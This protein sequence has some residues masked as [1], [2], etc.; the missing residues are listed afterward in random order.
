MSVPTWDSGSR[1][2]HNLYHCLWSLLWDRYT[3][4]ASTVCIVPIIMIFPPF[5]WHP[6]ALPS[7]LKSSQECHC[8]C[9][10]QWSLQ[11]SL[12]WVWVAICLRFETNT[13]FCP[14]ETSVIRACISL[15]LTFWWQAW[16]PST[17]DCGT[18]VWLWDV[19][20]HDTD[21][22]P[23]GVWS[24]GHEPWHPVFRNDIWDL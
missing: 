22:D 16:I 21:I 20:V 7:D 12:L 14:L 3:A 1:T 15:P 13:E 9:Y 6:S 18:S 2:R 11:G 10:L 23:A 4:A 5:L 17:G 19:L 8:L 24:A